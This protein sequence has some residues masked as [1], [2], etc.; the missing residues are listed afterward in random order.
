MEEMGLLADALRQLDEPFLVVVVGEFNSGKS[1]ARARARARRARPGAARCG[2]LA[3]AGRLQPGRPRPSAPASRAPAQPLLVGVRFVARCSQDAPGQSLFWHE[4]GACTA[5]Q[6]SRVP[7]FLQ[8][9]RGRAA[10][11]APGA[12]RRPAGGRSGRPAVQ[13]EG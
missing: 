1:T 11:V 2:V 8:D 5:N 12:A 9:V 6:R 3:G 4:R 10:I 7:S 13:R